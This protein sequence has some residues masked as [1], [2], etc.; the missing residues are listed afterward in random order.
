MGKVIDRDLDT[1]NAICGHTTL[2]PKFFI[3][4][5]GTEI[6]KI[7]AQLKKDED[8]RITISEKE[9]RDYHNITAV[10]HE[11]DGNDTTY[12]DEDKNGKREQTR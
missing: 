10:S 5:R 11:T 2:N 6:K 8:L 9:G 12:W 1:T 7:V 4:F 3:L